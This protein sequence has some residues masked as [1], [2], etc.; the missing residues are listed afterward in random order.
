MA[1]RLGI[2]MGL[3]DAVAKL[4]RETGKGGEVMIQNL[5]EATY[6]DPLL[7]RE[8][9][10]KTIKTYIKPKYRLTFSVVRV[11]RHL[12]AME[13]FKDL[14]RETFV[15]TPLAEVFVSD[16]PISAGLISMC[17]SRKSCCFRASR[18]S[19]NGQNC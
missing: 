11:V 8:C 1:I 6:V 3:F 9:N 19:P 18:C 4:S 10:P 2:D 7:V 13:V 17:V 15:P 12:A 14:G 5:A 16:N